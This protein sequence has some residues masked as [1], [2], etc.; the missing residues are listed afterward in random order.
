[1]DKK[2]AETEKGHGF[3]KKTPFQVQSLE[4]FYSEEKYPTREVMDGYAAALNLTYKQIRTWFVE[5]RRR[6]KRDKEAHSP[7]K[8]PIKDHIQVCRKD[9]R[10]APASSNK[11]PGH[12]QVILSKGYIMKRIFR[13]DG[14]PLGVE[15]DL[16][17]ENAF[18]INTPKDLHSFLDDQRCP[19]RRKV[20]ESCLPDPGTLH[21]RDT[22]VKKY[23]IGKGLMTTWRAVTCNKEFPTGIS[24][25]DERVASIPPS[26]NVFPEDPVP[27]VSKR[28]K[29]QLVQRQN[30][31]RKQVQEK[32]NPPVKN[33]EDPCNKEKNQ[34]KPHSTECK[35]SVD[36]LKSLEQSDALVILVDDEELEVR[37][38]Q[39]APNSLSCPVH[40][41]S[42]GR[43]GCPLCKDLLPR[44]PPQIVKMKQPF[45]TRPWE[46][47]PELVK[48][49][50]KVFRFLYDHA[51]AIKL[52][53]F[54]LDEFA[55]AFN[56]KDSVLLGNIHV[57]LLKMFLLDVEKEMSAGFFPRA[58]KDCR[59]L[60]FLHFVREQ[61][62]D[63][64][65]WVQSLN[66]LT[67]A[68]ILRQVMI[69][70][71]FGSKSNP[72][73]RELFTK[74]R[75]HM[76]KYG[77]QPRTLKGELFRMLSEKGSNGLKVSELA[78]ASQIAALDLP[79]TPEEM[80]EL[81]CSAL[82]SDIT[83]FEKIAP[84]S[85]RLRVDP[86]IKGKEVCESDSEDSGSVSDESGDSSGSS[87]SDESES[88]EKLHLAVCKP[89]IIKHQAGRKIK[90]QV[91]ANYNEI[92]ESYTGEAWVLGLMEG[93]YSSLSI[94]E[95]LD[96]L[97]ALVD[98]ASSACSFRTKEPM[99]T[100]ASTFY[101]YQN[102]ASG[103]KIKKS[104]TSHHPPS[105][106]IFEGPA[107]RAEETRSS[108]YSFSK[109]P[110]EIFSKASE[111]GH[112]SNENIT[113]D[114]TEESLPDVH[115]QRSIYLGS[116]RRYNSYWLFLGP[117]NPND[118]GHRRV[119]VESS[120]DGHWEVIDTPQAFHALL[121]VLDCRGSREFR[122]FSSLE[123]RKAVLCQAM[124]DHMTA[125]IGS[126]AG[127][128]FDPSDTDM[129]TVDSSSPIS[130]I[131]NMLLPSESTSSILP[132]SGSI[133][134][135]LGNNGK[136]KKQRWD[137]SQAFDK[138]IWNSFY[139]S[140]NAVKD[141]ERSFMDSLVRCGSCHDLYWR[142]E[143][144]CKICH[145]TFEVDFD[146]EE[147]YAIH[148][149]TCKETEDN[150]EHPMYKVHPSQLQAL[151]AAV[152]AI[153]LSLPEVALVGAWKRSGRKLWVKRLRRT[154]SLPELLQVLTYFVGSINEE[155]LLECTSAAGL[156][157]TIDEIIV[158]FQTIPQTTSAV[159]LWMVKLDMLIASHLDKLRS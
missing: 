126:R 41:A 159:A 98:L 122:L 7:T 124:H 156:E 68:E 120:E 88:Y 57:S 28:P 80:E 154:S 111:N 119:Y 105:A 91:L 15:F 51:T 21:S 129:S 47:S 43:H 150:C 5:R 12:L 121:S 109:Y 140:L 27:Q 53:L 102:H 30:S 25:I 155:W 128:G 31:S 79:N 17:P 145:V 72:M 118:P 85:Y 104:V 14:P 95:K 36:E 77:L 19:K 20:M 39:A 37:E 82:S 65:F 113:T 130:D 139:S 64:N 1:M 131:D 56:D 114:P 49:L 24:F 84:S 76:A 54:T 83:L 135:G 8:K 90:G 46:S 157:R 6:E 4:N 151:K 134:H 141:N 147:R 152:H 97:V 38:M 58:S 52:C 143:K 94:N 55:Q 74:E 87:S 158:Y 142:D 89:P 132:A 16:I 3:K 146:L 106:E 78:K 137:R 2:V 133:A 42:N 11:Q 103:A 93:E 29:Q 71:G 50:F 117:C 92:D 138:W 99:R 116:D 33:R 48:K 45:C 153:E 60:G 148:V 115:P 86:H 125:E 75:N 26:V 34:K 69:A 59:F 67:W 44:F 81:I 110:S 22:P 123:A 62:F 35:L 107:H 73:R 9:K 108:P 63:L 149:A 66:P 32:R 40:V 70:A 127:N 100:V 13:K 112:S 61:E 23:G 10:R 18:N 136:E 96:G 101:N 144:H